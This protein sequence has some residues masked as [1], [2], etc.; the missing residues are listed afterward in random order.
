MGEHIPG[1][2]G[3]LELT[4]VWWFGSRA[5]S[6]SAGT[7]VNA[8]CSVVRDTCVLVTVEPA[9]VSPWLVFLP[10]VGENHEGLVL[11]GG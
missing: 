11:G 7:C 10:E 9:V 5:Y 2:L 1:A 8:G 6:K 3:I 4:G